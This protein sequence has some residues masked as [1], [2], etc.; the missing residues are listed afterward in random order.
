[1]LP[2]INPLNFGIVPEFTW[3]A[4]SKD[5]SIVDDISAVSDL[6]GFSDIV[7]RDQNA[8]LLGF[9]MINEFLDL[10]HSDRI[11]PRKRFVQKDEFGRNY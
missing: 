2:K 7:V 10:Q 5:R 11:D 6:Q 8:D 3:S 9:Q 4:G 1:M